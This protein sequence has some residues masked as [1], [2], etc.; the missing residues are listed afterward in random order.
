MKRLSQRI[1]NLA[2]K[3]LMWQRF[4]EIRIAS[5]ARVHL[6][7]IRGGRSC[8]LSVGDESIVS[9]FLTFERPGAEVIIGSRTFIGKSNIISSTRVEVGD[10]V[11]ISW[12]VTVVD[13]HS[14]SLRFSERSHD[15]QAWRHGA[16]VWDNI[17][18]APTCI[19][20]KA[21]LGFGASIL[22]GVTVGTGAVIGAC[23]V[24]TKD[25]PAWT[26]YAGNPA[27]LVRPLTA[28]EISP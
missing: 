19:Q 23:S 5:S 12:G 13:H 24:V 16:K 4:A 8:R 10:D 14:H 27:R 22:S 21:W 18:T 25:V 17:R 15:V 3:P 1:A 11:L 20:S 2:L 6:A 9:A 28:E 26:V 7:R